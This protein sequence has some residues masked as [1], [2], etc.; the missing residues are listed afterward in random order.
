MVLQT[1][2][3]KR[4]RGLE[5][6]IKALSDATWR[7]KKKAQMDNVEAGLSMAT[8]EISDSHIVHTDASTVS[9]LGGI[10]KTSYDRLAADRVRDHIELP[11][12]IKTLPPYMMEVLAKPELEEDM[13]K[14]TKKHYKKLLENGVRSWEGM[15][16]SLFTASV[17]S[18]SSHGHGPQILAQSY[19]E[20]SQI[21]AKMSTTSSITTAASSRVG[22]IL[23][24]RQR[25]GSPGSVHSQQTKFTGNGSSLHTSQSLAMLSRLVHSPRD[26]SPSAVQNVP[27]RI[28]NS[29]SSN[30]SKVTKSSKRNGQ[31]TVSRNQ[32]RLAPLTNN[33]A[34]SHLHNDGD[35]NVNVG[36][37]GL[38]GLSLDDGEMDGF[39]Y[40]GQ[41]NARQ[42]SLHG[43]GSGSVQS[44]SAYSGFN[45]VSVGDSATQMTQPAALDPVF[46]KEQSRNSW[47]RKHAVGKLRRA[48]ITWG[49][50]TF[51]DPEK[52][53]TEDG[54]DGNGDDASTGGASVRMRRSNTN[55][56]DITV[57][58]KIQQMQ[59]NA[60]GNG[61]ALSRAG[62]AQ[63]LRYGHTPSPAA[64]SVTVKSRS[65]TVY[66]PDMQIFQDAAALPK[67]KASDHGN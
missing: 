14:Y 33:S 8:S 23:Q 19:D 53:D 39:L 38:D 21:R 4:S 36:E 7:K 9:S 20:Y 3:N 46:F 30:S 22:S 47:G 26:T 18:A 67:K 57:S 51:V 5:K 28:G 56:T 50:K 58:K 2:K 31:K 55:N 17:Y 15:E 25:A 48:E 61:N 54:E 62:T 63:S 41:P 16:G 34:S 43:R 44:V 6:A 1:E 42:N 29:T 13:D 60:H 35:G 59:A 37:S 49:M 12:S 27:F 10:Y 45:G 11:P 52:M 32:I 64:T 65:L 66:H 40:E 24:S